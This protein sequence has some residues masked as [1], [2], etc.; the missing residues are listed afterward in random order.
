MTS[1]NPGLSTKVSQYDKVSSFLVASLIL[2]AFVTALLLILYFSQLDWSPSLMPVYRSEKLA[3]EQT[4]AKGVAEDIEEPGVEE[5]P[6]VTEPQLA[7]LVK[8]LTNDPSSNYA[9]FEAVSGNMSQVG[10]GSGGGDWREIGNDDD[11]G[12]D[13]FVPDWKRWNIRYSSMSKEEYAQQLEFFG[14]ELGA[15]SPNESVIQYVSQFATEPIRRTGS[16]KAEKRVA[17][18]YNKESLLAKWDADILTNCGIS[19]SQ[20]FLM[21]FYPKQTRAELLRLESV[22]LNGR[23]LKRVKKT[24]F[25]VRPD[26]SGGFEYFVLDI[27]YR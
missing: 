4:K 25:G 8:A 6:D 2:A 3:G 15:V 14:I 5:L 18:R 9:A 12:P 17:F 20:K 26:G 11:D 13:D 10:P 19:T 1:A 7:E 16:R 22:A 24:T 21:Q 27:E 23:S